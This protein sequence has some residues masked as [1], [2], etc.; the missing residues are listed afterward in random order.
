MASGPGLSFMERLLVIMIYFLFDIGL[1][2][3]SI[4]SR[5]RFSSLCFLR[6]S[7]FHLGD[8]ICWHTTLPNSPL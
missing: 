6:V 3:F 7:S 1:F 4:P 8:L 5:V 2:R